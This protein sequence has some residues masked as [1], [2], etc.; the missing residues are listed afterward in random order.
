MLIA[1]ALLLAHPVRAA[2]VYKLRPGDTF[3]SVAAA[4]GIPP[5]ALLMANS[6]TFKDVPAVGTVVRLTGELPERWTIRAGQTLTQIVLVSGRPLAEWTYLNDRVD[7]ARLRPGQQLLM[8]DMLEV[9]YK[10]HILGP[11]ET[12]GDVARREHLDEEALRNANSLTLDAQPAA[13]TPILLVPED[14]V[15][16][17][18]MYFWT[19]RTGQTLWSIS[20][21]TGNPVQTL[22]A[23]SGIIGTDIRAGQTLIVSAEACGGVSPSWLAAH[24]RQ[25]R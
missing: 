19:V 4:C 2:D 14:D 5:R 15:R 23:D 1:I 10:T 24:P 21:I 7:P 22:A 3:E 16:N 6:L 18:P 13:G 11:H 12:L 9:R 25:G 8:P 17:S 20:T